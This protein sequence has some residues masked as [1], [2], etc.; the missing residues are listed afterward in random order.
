MLRF[1][2]HSTCLGDIGDSCHQ[3]RRCHYDRH[4]QHERRMGS[5]P[6]RPHFAIC[7][8]IWLRASK[9]PRRRHLSSPK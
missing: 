6:L 7:L 8:V 1:R 4:A 2:R 9:G 5:W 3:L